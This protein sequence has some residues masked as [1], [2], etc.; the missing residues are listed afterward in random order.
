VEIGFSK[1][2]AV[3]I[4]R[5][6]EKIAQVIVAKAALLHSIVGHVVILYDPF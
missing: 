2:L 6:Q 1:E 5:F 4:D 3:E